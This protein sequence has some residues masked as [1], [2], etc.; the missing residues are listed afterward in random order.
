MSGRGGGGGGVYILGV[1][2]KG[3][4]S[5]EGG[6]GERGLSCNQSGAHSPYAYF[7]GKMDWSDTHINHV[8]QLSKQCAI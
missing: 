1:R 2:F 3:V 4:H 7:G 5:P 6:G 8:H